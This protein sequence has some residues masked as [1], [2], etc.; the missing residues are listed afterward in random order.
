M[1]AVGWYIKVSGLG[2]GVR[3]SKGQERGFVRNTVLIMS[4]GWWWL[5]VGG[6]RSEAKHTGCRKQQAKIYMR[7]QAGF[8]RDQKNSDFPIRLCRVLLLALHEHRYK[9]SACEESKT[10]SD[11]IKMCL[12][13]KKCLWCGWNLEKKKIISSFCNHLIILFIYLYSYIIF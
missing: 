3:A 11:S 2:S 4:V 7:V 10:K 13:M 6:L 9:V 8:M 5:S 1:D 12:H